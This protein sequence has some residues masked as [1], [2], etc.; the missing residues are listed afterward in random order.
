MAYNMDYLVG[1]LVEGCVILKWERVGERDG[2]PKNLYKVINIQEI[3][4]GRE[5]LKNILHNLR[6]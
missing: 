2:C 5:I 6:L 3:L 1:W 4:E